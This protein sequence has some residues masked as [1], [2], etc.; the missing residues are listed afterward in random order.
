[1][2]ENILAI[3]VIGFNISLFQILWF[4]LR[5]FEARH[6]PNEETESLNK[7][8]QDTNIAVNQSKGDA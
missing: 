8:G 3:I 1:M 6:N 5:L 7:Q 4:T 2:N